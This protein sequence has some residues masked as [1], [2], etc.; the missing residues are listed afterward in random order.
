ERLVSG[1][2]P[3]LVELSKFDFSDPDNLVKLNIMA[4]A[5]P[6]TEQTLLEKMLETQNPDER[7][8]QDIY[9]VLLAAAQGGERYANTQQRRIEEALKNHQISPDNSERFKGMAEELIGTVH[10]SEPARASIASSYAVI[11][12]K[13]DD[14]AATRQ[15]EREE[16]AQAAKEEINFA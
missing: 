9:G 13:A 11:K 5:L 16:N 15:A 8:I 10:L 3:S 1:A 7:A 4:K 12:G 14:H 2:N 6:S